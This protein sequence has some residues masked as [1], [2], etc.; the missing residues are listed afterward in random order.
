MNILRC[1]VA[2]IGDPRVG[3]TCLVNQLI[4]N[5][6]NNTYQTT[7]GIE[8]NTHDAKLKDYTVQFHTLDCTG[9][10]V[11]RD[12]VLTQLKDVN[13]IIYVYDVTNQESFASI[14]LWKEFI[15]DQIKGH[16]VVELLVGNKVD[17]E[18]KIAIDEKAG[19]EFANTNKLKFYQTS[20][21]RNFLFI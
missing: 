12:L 9:F 13:F 15:K 11:F 14:K 10:S 1:K 7:L 5:Y 20:A 21:V 8:Y 4:K 6:F 16:N 19:K 3:K 18:K 2:I 17:L